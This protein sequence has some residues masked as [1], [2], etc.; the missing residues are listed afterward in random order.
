MALTVSSGDATLKLKTGAG[1]GAEFMDGLGYFFGK[2][3]SGISTVAYLRT[4][5]DAD[6]FTRAP[7][8][9]SLDTTATQPA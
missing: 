2:G 5:G 8:T 7:T 6:S 1:C 4:P 3:T 9:T